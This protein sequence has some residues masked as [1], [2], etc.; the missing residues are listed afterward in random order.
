LRGLLRTEVCVVGTLSEAI[1]RY[2]ESLAAGRRSP[3]YLNV[4]RST[5][6]Q[7]LRA[8]DR[9]L[10]DAASDVNAYLARRL[11][12]LSHNS[13][14]QEFHRVRQFLDYCVA[15]RW[16][17]R[18]PLRGLRAP[19]PQTVEID[20][21]SD[22]ELRRLLEAGDHIER[23]VIMVLLGSGMRL[24]ELGRLT[25]GDIHG[26]ELLLHGKGGK[27]RRVAPGRIALAALTSLPRTGDA[28]LS[29]GVSNLKR[30]LRV[31]S[32]RTY[33]HFHAHVLRHTFADRFIA[34]GGTVE[35]LSH[36]LGHSN[37]N[38]TMIYIR[39]HQRDRALEAQRRLNPCDAFLGGV[40]QEPK[41]LPFRRER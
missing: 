38:T 40:P 16:L 27:K 8:G 20:V 3:L 31:L 9:P 22:D 5:F 14:V 15:E 1:T 23:V 21:L 35:E 28:V 10:A 36:I 33:I 11:A 18:N 7:W 24:G 39:R 13:A 41:V 26:D 2:L 17:E 34:A 4:L 12:P 30:R 29:F 25:W 6:R 37:L 32:E 19:R